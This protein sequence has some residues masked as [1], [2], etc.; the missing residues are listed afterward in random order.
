MLLRAWDYMRRI[1]LDTCVWC[2]PFDEPSRRVG[3]EAE[4]FF[5]ILQGVD[6]KRFLILGSVVLEDEI[7]EI[8]AEKK[9]AAVI[10]LKTRAVSERIDVI[11]LPRQ[12]ELKKATGVNDEDAFHLA[13][14]LEGKANYFITVD[15]NILAKADRIERYGIKVRNP[16]DLKEAED[17]YGS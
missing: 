15:G 14:A 9:R 17:D 4:A 8:K 2:R 10:E 12:K 16:V 1:Y 7:H 11:S 6:E 3:E 5:K 13:A